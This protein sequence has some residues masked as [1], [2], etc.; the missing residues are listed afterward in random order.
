MNIDRE[1]TDLLQQ[2]GDELKLQAWLAGAELRHPSL[3]SHSA[4]QEVDALVRLRD[5]IR[6]QL[7][8]GKLEARDGFEQLE[9]R[10]HAL[11]RAAGLTS[12]ELEET[13]HDLLREIRDGYQKLTQHNVK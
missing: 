6:V 5:E 7:A 12:A 10:W 2:L 8:L 9:Q 3:Q 11:K 13:L 4:R 1:Q